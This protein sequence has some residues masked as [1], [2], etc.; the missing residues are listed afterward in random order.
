MVQRLRAL[1]VQ[2]KNDQTEETF[3]QNRRFSRDK[4]GR[5]RRNGDSSIY[6]EGRANGVIDG[7][8]L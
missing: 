7:G 8:Q 1:L 3:Q 4:R 5:Q 6:N 2:Y